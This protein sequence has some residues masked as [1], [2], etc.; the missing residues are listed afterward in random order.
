MPTSSDRVHV[1]ATDLG[2][3]F[4][5]LRDERRLLGLARHSFRAREYIWALRHVDLEIPEGGAL[6]IIGP[7]GSGKTTLLRVL[8]GV[9]DPSEG[10]REV[11]GRV[12]SLLT[13]GAGFQKELTGRENM[14]V[15]GAVLGMTRAEVERAAPDILEF[16][17]LGDA[18]DRPVK[19]YST[20]MF[21][22]LAFSV[23]ISARPEIL[24][25]DEVIGVGDAA[26]RARSNE[27]VA[28]LVRGGVTLLFVSHNTEMVSRLCPRSLVLSQGQPV[29]QGPTRDAVTHY[30][31]LVDT[32]AVERSETEFEVDARIQ[33][34]AGGANVDAL[35]ILDG[36]GR[37]RNRFAV[38]ERVSLRARVRLERPVRDPALWLD[39]TN[40]VRPLSHIDLGT[41]PGAFAAGDELEVR[42]DLSLHVGPGTYQF[43]L[44]ARGGGEES[45]LLRHRSGP[46]H[47]TASDS[48]RAWG[49]VDLEPEAEVVPVP[50]RMSSTP[51]RVEA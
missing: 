30:F 2:K 11:I 32:P 16:C 9:T 3:R 18:I 31:A 6:G 42:A 8:A 7:N 36:G 39:A 44:T 35:E 25:I 14:Y 21:M 4:V 17:G 1:R 34:V 50:R 23:A 43:V 10:R 48:T 29:F 27:R 47:V 12:A 51:R 22:R 24:L 46:V 13:I 45:L 19:H 20:G 15:G 40:G 33:R 38:G 41:G 5:L 37:P 49:F 28:D 26:F